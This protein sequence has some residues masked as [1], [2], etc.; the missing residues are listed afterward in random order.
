MTGTSI[1]SSASAARA[2]TT[3]SSPCASWKGMG[4][5]K[6][7]QE[8]GR[9]D[10]PE[11]VDRKVWGG[12]GW[13]DLEWVWAESGIDLAGPSHGGEGGQGV[14]TVKSSALPEISRLS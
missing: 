8:G 2:T 14:L 9:T 4:E 11:G 13:A 1:T 10:E 6:G 5:A 12:Q 7:E 3:S